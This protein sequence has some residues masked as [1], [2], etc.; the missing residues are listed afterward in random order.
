MGEGYRIGSQVQIVPAM[1][2]TYS[3]GLIGSLGT[4]GARCLI[5]DGTGKIYMQGDQA[6]WVAISYLRLRP[7]FGPP[8][9]PSDHDLETDKGKE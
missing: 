5:W 6:A 2:D 4:L 1:Y 7:V 9:E 8:T 3:F